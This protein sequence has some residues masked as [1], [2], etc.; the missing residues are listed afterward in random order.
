MTTYAPIS[1]LEAVNL[2]L[3]VIGEQPVNSIE[4]GVSLANQAQR[5][6]HETSREVQTIGL[7][8]NTESEYQLSLDGDSKVPV[9]S[10]L[11]FD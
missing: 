5:L 2:M 4:S 10:M 6:L 11:A 1:E 8:C 3:E 9:A 7:N